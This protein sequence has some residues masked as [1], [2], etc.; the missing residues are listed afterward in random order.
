MKN[1][2]D[3]QL[4]DFIKNQSV[5]A[6]MYIGSNGTVLEYNSRTEHLIGKKADRL[7]FREIFNDFTTELSIEY[8]ILE[9]GKLFSQKF[10]PKSGVPETYIFR[11]FKSGDSVLAIGEPDIS[12]ATLINK[13]TIVTHNQKNPFIGIIAH[14]LRNP[15]GII[16]GYSNLFL[17]DYSADINER[18][19]K[20]LKS[21]EKSSEFMQHL[22]NELLD[23]A[24]IESGKMKLD[25]KQNNLIDLINQNIEL[26]KMLGEKKGISTRFQIVDSVPLVCFDQRKID[27][28]LNN[29]LSNAYKFSMP[30]TT[31]RVRLFPEGDSIVVEISDQGQGI[32]E[33]EQEKLFKPFG[34]T[35]V[36]STAGEESSGL[37]LAIVKNI[38][39]GHKGKIW[40]ESKVGIGS[41]FCFSLPVNH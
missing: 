19:K 32:P 5:L 34:K 37:G 11:F 39:V 14:D 26:N 40:F 21:I 9:P 15:I 6:Y 18:Q 33:E 24:A 35:S 13:D 31:V 16:K 12:N 23:F 28:V 4:F 41:T 8:L 1:N 27:Q 22:V 38:I 10:I 7:H 30:G 3:K 25:I 2:A 29:L 20:M 17:Q 36:R